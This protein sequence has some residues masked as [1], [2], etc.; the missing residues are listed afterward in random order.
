M[1]LVAGDC[2]YHPGVA[3]IRSLLGED[4]YLWWAQTPFNDTWPAS[5]QKFGRWFCSCCAK[6]WNL[7]FYI[8][9]N[10][11]HLKDLKPGNLCK[12]HRANGS[13][14]MLSLH[15]FRCWVSIFSEEG[16]LK[17]LVYTVT[18]LQRLLMSACPTKSKEDQRSPC[19][20]QR[21]KSIAALLLV[22][23]CCAEKYVSFSRHEDFIVQPKD[24]TRATG[25]AKN[26][27]IWDEKFP[28]SFRDQFE[29]E[30]QQVKQVKVLMQGL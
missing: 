30:A 18:W 26:A 22:R 23:Y 10:C 8:F 2:I 6:S 12:G 27:N 24:W 28:E 9:T 19:Q 20:L 13:K 25:I 21:Q 3:G 1:V 17:T 11:I 14:W 4:I 29:D 5:V 7:S 16:R 15:L